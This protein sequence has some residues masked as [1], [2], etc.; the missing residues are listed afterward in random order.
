MP[1]KYIFFY[2]IV[3]VA[4]EIKLTT[5][6]NPG[7]HVMEGLPYAKGEYI[8]IPIVQGQNVKTAYMD[9][10]TLVLNATVS[11]GSSISGCFSYVT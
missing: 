9:G 10:T 3:T 11:S 5:N 1:N 8:N 2:G 7:I 4:F 6:A